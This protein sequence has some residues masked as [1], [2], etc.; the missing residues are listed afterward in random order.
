MTNKDGKV[1]RKGVN[2][3]TRKFSDHDDV[4]N[5]P[6][7]C[8]AFRKDA[9]KLGLHRLDYEE[10]QRKREDKVKN[11]KPQAL[12]VVLHFVMSFALF[13]S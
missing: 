9:A 12:L 4:V 10:K 5:E 11:R 1:N 13:L 8:M 2:T 3:G 6:R 7:R